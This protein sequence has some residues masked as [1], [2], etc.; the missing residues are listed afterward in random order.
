MNKRINVDIVGWLERKFG[1]VYPAT[2]PNVHLDCPY[3][4]DNKQRLYVTFEA[5]GKKKQG[6]GW[7]QKEQVRHDF[8]ELYR[9]HENLTDAE[10]MERLYGDPTVSPYGKARKA[11]DEYANR[12]NIHEVAEAEKTIIQWPSK[13]V[14]LWGLSPQEWKKK[15]PAYMVNRKID[16]AM[17]EQYLLGYCGAGSEFV[18]RMIA[19]IYQF[20]KLVG[21]QGRAMHDSIKPKYRFMAGLTAGDY[22]YNLDNALGNEWVILVEGIFDVWGV[23]RAGFNNVV[24]SFGKHLTEIGARTLTTHFKR[25]L[26]FWDTDALKEIVKLA[27]GL[28]GMIDL[29]V[30]FLNG[31]DP[32]ETSDEE[33]VKAIH[34]VQ[35]FSRS[36]RRRALIMSRS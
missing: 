29:S 13:Y 10:T 7:C 2:Y 30:T 22:L 5:H 14:P 28:E 3:C 12:K 21:F 36:F 16:Q 25:V 33:V 18:G 34:N 6:W 35:T 27:E 32:D 24:A 23:R 1:E 15:V 4:A 20:G 8:Y 9:D 17:C 19:P 31:K 26:L 11:L